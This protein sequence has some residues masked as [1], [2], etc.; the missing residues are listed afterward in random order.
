MASQ[1]FYFY[2]QT[3]SCGVFSCLNFKTQYGFCNIFSL[4]LFI[5]NIDDINIDL[6]IYR[7]ICLYIC[8]SFT[9]QQLYVSEICT[10]SISEMFVYKHTETIA[11]VLK[12][13]T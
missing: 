9:L 12:Q 5:I 4:L 3:L 11:Y 2:C 7:Y 10:F 6:K 13:D 8:Q 1:I